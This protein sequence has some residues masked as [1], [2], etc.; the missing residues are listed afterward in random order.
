MLKKIYLHDV[1]VAS[2]ADITEEHCDFI[3]SVDVTTISCLRCLT[4]TLN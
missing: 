3:I 2:C 1:C 4:A